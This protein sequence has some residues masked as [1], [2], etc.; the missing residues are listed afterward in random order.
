MKPLV[1]RACAIAVAIVAVHA[2]DAL[3][4]K[5][6]NRSAAVVAGL[7]VGVVLAGTAAVLV[8]LRARATVRGA[9]ALLIGTGAVIEGAGVTAAHL[10]RGSP[11]GADFTGIASFLAG[12]VLLAIGGALLTGR[13]HR[14]WR[15]L[16]APAAG[17]LLLYVVAPLVM[18]VIA[19]H[20][21]AKGVE[22]RTPADAG[23]AYRDVTAVAPD[24]VTLSGWYMP[25]R[26]GAAVVVVPGAWST[27]SDALDQAVVL[28][29]HGYGVLDLDPRGHGRSGGTAMDFGWYGQ[30]DVAAA[31]DFLGR[32]PDVDSARI[33]GLGLSM[34]AEELLTAAAGDSRL[35]AVVSEGGTNRTFD[36]V[37]PVA[38]DQWLMVPAFW[39][40]TT[41][42]DLISPAAPP[43]ALTDAVE[44]IAPR[45]VLLIA[46]SEEPELTLTRHLHAAAPQTTQ[47]WEPANTAHTQG[48]A[49]HPAQWSARVLGF[50]D[51]ALLR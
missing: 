1:R 46:A 38:G 32:Q 50:L 24:G 18:A 30:A 14:W 26:N 10:V 27:R 44:S 49:T 7:A 41:A 22:A 2:L 25:S 33:G 48:L 34:G 17:V 12:L 35:R 13:L 9:V 28:A 6:G 5:P 15:L 23:L 8:S 16:A 31:L 36:D 37:R 42:S 20:P 21:P 45:P 43:M 29:R 39:M 40:I 47:L 11:T 4:E 19:T 3:I 51:A